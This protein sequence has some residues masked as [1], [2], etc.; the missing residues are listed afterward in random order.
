[1]LAV[2]TRTTS[3]FV[4]L[5]MIAA[6]ML[7]AVPRARAATTGQYANGWSVNNNADWTPFPPSPNPLGPPDNNC[8]GGVIPGAWAEFTFGGFGLSGSDTVTGIEVSVKYRSSGTHSLQLKNGGV[9]VGTSKT[10]A[11]SPVASFCSSTAIVT[12]GGAGDTWGSGLTTADFNAGTVSVRLTEG[13]SNLDLDSIELIVHFTPGGDTPPTADAGGTYTGIE[14]APIAVSGIGSTD[15]NGITTYEWDCLNDGTFEFSSASPTGNSCTYAD[16]GSYTVALRV[17]DTIGQQDTDTAAVTVS[18]VAP[19]ITSI[20]VSPASLDEGNSVSVTG[21]FVDPALASETHSGSAL[22]SDGETTPL[23]V[24]SGTFA[25]S[26][27]FPDDHPAT[28]T[29]L[30]TFTVVI[31]INDGD[32]GSDSATSP[33]VTVRNVAP[34]IDSLSI[35]SPIDEDDTATLSGTFSDPALGVATEIFVLDIDWDGDTVF[36]ETVAVTGGSFSVAHQYLDDDPT[37]TPADTF[38]VNVRL[39]DDDLGAATGFVVLTVDNVA[40]VITSVVSD[41]TFADKAEEGETVTVSGTFTDTGTLDTHVAAVDWGDGTIT[42][43]TVVQGAGSGTFSASHAYAVGGVFTVTVTLIDDDT[44]AD[45]ETTTAVVTGVGVNGGV[46][47]VVGTAGD[48]HVH[49]KTV[50]D[51]IDVKASFTSPRHRR[52]DA[53]SITSVEIWLCEGNDHGN[54]HQNITIPATIHGGDG[55]DTLWGGSADDSMF[56]DDGNDRLWGRNGDDLLDGGDGDDRLDGGKGDDDLLGQ[57][58][59]DKLFGRDG[60]DFLDGGADTDFCRPGPG[61]D[62]VVNCET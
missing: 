32:G 52:F 38:N 13:P 50:Q 18:N 48:D 30:D 44:G 22:W 25:T 8:T 54:V 33:D 61:T 36:D 10:L 45:A 53:S 1:M 24:G 41:A 56:G 5:A 12:A 60:D 49:V 27:T 43:A 51:E 16:D 6:L 31:T 15:D 58:G 46:L 29:V 4:V 59:D 19:A 17:T 34:T 40:P 11:A 62:T 14:G 21:T 39:G 35:T 28:A 2:R 3:V 26:R 20:T 37:G 57:A 9:N 23:S 47:Q 42:P 7:L 55:N